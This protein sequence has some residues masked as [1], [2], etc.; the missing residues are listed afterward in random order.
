MVAYMRP[1]VIVS[2]G[3]LADFESLYLTNLIFPDVYSVVYSVPYVLPFSLIPLD[4][5]L[6]PITF[7]LPEFFL[8]C[9]DPNNIFFA[10]VWDSSIKND[11][12]RF[13]ASDHLLV[14]PCEQ[15]LRFFTAL[16]AYTGHCNCAPNRFA[17]KTPFIA[18]FITPANRWDDCNSMFLQ[19]CPNPMLPVVVVNLHRLGKIR[20]Q[21]EIRCH[22][23]TK[24]LEHG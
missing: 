19:I 24:L 16:R 23:A 2:I 14:S 13:Q 1:F 4:A 11:G 8:E 6:P 22:N 3:V 18:G 9:P 7:G 20:I 17:V 12:L 10:S 5:P 15:F 21:G